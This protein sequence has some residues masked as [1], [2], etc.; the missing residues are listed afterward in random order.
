MQSP[1]PQRRATAFVASATIRLGS[2]PLSTPVKTPY[3]CSRRPSRCN[4]RLEFISRLDARGATI[5]CISTLSFHLPLTVNARSNLYHERFV[6]P[7]IRHQRTLPSVFLLH[8]KPTFCRIFFSRLSV[9]VSLVS[10]RS[11]V[12]DGVG[13]VMPRS[14]FLCFPLFSVKTPRY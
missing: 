4:F 1:W 2:F 9:F 14:L 10:R 7:V 6:D 11:S 3:P 8:T 13:V 5:C 12:H